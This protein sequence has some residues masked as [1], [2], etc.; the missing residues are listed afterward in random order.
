MFLAPKCGHCDKIGT[1]VQAIEPDHAAYKQ[2]A[3]C[4]K[5]CNAILGVTGYYDAGKVAKDIE[6]KVDTLQQRLSQ[7]EHQIQQIGH[8][9]QRRG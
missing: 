7:L 1:K 9:L 3:I 2:I 8:F 6:A 4:C 5:W